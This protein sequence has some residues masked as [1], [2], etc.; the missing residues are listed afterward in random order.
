MTSIPGGDLINSGRRSVLT[1]VGNIEKIEKGSN[2]AVPPADSRLYGGGGARA[3]AAS[4][5]TS[6]PH[7]L[8][9]VD[10]SFLSSDQFHV[11]FVS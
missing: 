4:I 2:F 9:T 7:Q 6:G 11:L 5:S 3:A 1:K 10:T 8:D